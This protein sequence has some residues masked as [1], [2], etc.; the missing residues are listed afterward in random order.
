MSLFRLLT[1]ICFIA[2]SL[3]AMAPKFPAPVREK[4]TLFQLASAQAR[5]HIDVLLKQLLSGIT[6]HSSIQEII[7]RLNDLRNLLPAEV[8]EKSG[9]ESL[10][11]NKFL[12]SVIKWVVSHIESTT[13]S[14]IEFCNHPEFIALMQT[15]PEN[16][17]IKILK[18]CVF[19]TLA[20]D[21]E[22]ELIA[23]LGQLARETEQTIE[24]TFQALVPNSFIRA[25]LQKYVV[26]TY[27][28]IHP[29]CIKKIDLD[30]QS[31]NELQNQD[32][33]INAVAWLGNRS[34]IAVAT[35]SGDIVIIGQQPNAPTI[36]TLEGNHTE[37][38]TSLLYD[39]VQQ[40]LVS[41][42]GDRTVKMWDLNTRQCI[43]TYNLPRSIG[44]AT[45]VGG[46]HYLAV[47]QQAHIR[48]L[49]LKTGSLH[50]LFPERP[51]NHGGTI[52]SLTYSAHDN[53]L[54]STSFDRKVKFWDLATGECIRTLNSTSLDSVLE[55]VYL[56][57]LNRVVINATDDYTI[58]VWDLN[59]VQCLDAHNTIGF[60]LHETLAQAIVSPYDVHNQTRFTFAPE[61]NAILVIENG[62][63][64]IYAPWTF[65]QLC[66]VSDTNI[67]GDA[68]LE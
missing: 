43:Q 15:I 28:W 34:E 40:Q 60:A 3:S 31:H 45:F 46:T 52:N 4:P 36:T 62:R 10:Y 33:T 65:E 44:A 57:L 68:S 27:Q 5:L 59:P 14:L 37:E 2:P 35:Y 66:M 11:E 29:R 12:E 49:D 56:P 64:K 53:R 22:S 47:A 42:S 63:L 24:A 6:K 26:D 67:N 51:M 39:P 7:A 50:H 38:I 16:C 20:Y 13:H 30:P 55:V 23:H 41:T 32:Y 48:I 58:R 17:Q 21:L 8:Y 1:L 54:I 18:N 25:L 9:L 61:L 19:E